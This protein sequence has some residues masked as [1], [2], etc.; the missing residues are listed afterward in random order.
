MNTEQNTIRVGFTDNHPCSYLVGQEE[1]VAVA[2]GERLHNGEQYDMLLAN[3]FRRS[4][5]M[6]YK[7][8]CDHCHACQPLRIVVADFSPSTSQKR[9]LNKARH[10]EWTLKSELDA[11]WFTLYS[12]YIEARHATGSMYPPKEAEFSQFARCDWLNTQFLH[13]YDQGR[14]IA[15]A[16]TDILPSSA[17]AFYTFY[18]PEHPLS[19][20]TLGVL[21]QLD[22]CRQAQKTWLYLGYQIDSCPAMNYKVRFQRHQKL[23]NQRWQG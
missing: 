11:E 15:V 20:G 6:I 1:R 17:S 3:G 19:L 22:Y 23:V 4:G 8:H 16:V 18:D 9:L 12:R 5:G 13:I 7:P 10:L 21:L 14:L 2:L